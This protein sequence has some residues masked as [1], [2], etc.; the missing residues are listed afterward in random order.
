MES[1]FR[2]Q[3]ATNG[4][5]G[6]WALSLMIAIDKYPSK[7]STGVVLEVFRCLQSLSNSSFI[8]IY[9]IDFWLSIF[10]EYGEN[11]DICSEGYITLNNLVSKYKNVFESLN[12]E[13]LKKILD[14]GTKSKVL[15]DDEVF[16]CHSILL[17]GTNGMKIEEPNSY[18]LLPIM[19]KIL[20]AKCIFY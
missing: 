15:S 8:S 13:N 10:L 18:L 9:V 16:K 19:F 20:K 5:T 4:G 12:C 17:Y 7:F 14:C 1:A 2:I 11:A 6:P 3:P